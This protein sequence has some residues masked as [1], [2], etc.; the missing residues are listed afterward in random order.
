MGPEAQTESQSGE[1]T[2]PQA[3]TFHV[4]TAVL[5]AALALAVLLAYANHFHNDFH[6]DDSH[7]IGGNIFIKKLSNI[8]H[9]FTNAATF[10][11]QP[12]AQTWRP[13]VSTTIAIDYAIARGLKPFAFH[14]DTFFWYL[15]Q[16]V[17][18]FDLFRR[19]MDAADPNPTNRWTALA[20]TACSR[21]TH[22]V[23]ES[24]ATERSR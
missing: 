21:P 1:I 7:T 12:E 16:L 6:F 15:V 3:R 9:F 11:M 5:L 20:A 17:L 4:P 24:S 13:L 18:M 10:S 23:N 19:L 2:E 22:S 14:V 8:P